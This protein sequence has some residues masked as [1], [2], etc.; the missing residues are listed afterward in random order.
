MKE[1]KGMKIR[2][3]AFMRKVLKMKSFLMNLAIL[4][5]ILGKSYEKS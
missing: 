2:T 4:V 1:K 5:F 3:T